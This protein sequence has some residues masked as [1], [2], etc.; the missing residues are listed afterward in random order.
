M[1]TA[2]GFSDARRAAH[3]AATAALARGE[4]LAGATRAVV[5]A[6]DAIFDQARIALDLDPMLARM[7]CAAGCSWCCHQIVGVTMAELAL[8]TETIAAMPPDRQARIKARAADAMATGR[9]MDQGQWWAARIRCPL[10]EDDGLC[11]VHAERPLPCRAFNSAD[12][13]LCRRSYL[14]EKLRTP[15][16]AAQH[17]IWANAQAGLIQALTEA[18][19][20]AGPVA[21]AEGIEAMGATSPSGP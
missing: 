21:L 16:L 15:V 5:A 19:I 13:D 3:A 7:A 12:A 2:P 11:G 1:A 17:G 18:G 14:G 20:A 9:G 6:T 4:G 8:L 10:L